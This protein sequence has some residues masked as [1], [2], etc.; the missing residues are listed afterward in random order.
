MASGLSPSSL[1]LK[2]L[3][4]SPKYTT[5]PSVKRRLDQPPDSAGSRTPD[6]SFETMALRWND[7]FADEET[8]MEAGGGGSVSVKEPQ[9]ISP[10]RAKL[11]KVESWLLK[12][13]WL[14][15]GLVTTVLIIY[16]FV[17]ISSRVT[18][19]NEPEGFLAKHGPITYKVIFDAGS[20]G[21]RVQ[22]FKFE[23]VGDKIKLDPVAP[24]SLTLF[25]KVDGGLSNYADDPTAAEDGLRWLVNEAIANVPEARG[26]QVVVSAT[27]GLRMLPSEKAEAL[28]ETTR[29]VMR[30]SP[31]TLRS[32]DD[33]YIMDGVDEAKF[34]WMTVDFAYRYAGL[35]SAVIDLG[36]GS[37]QLA[38]GIKNK[39][40]T[41]AVRAEYGS[42]LT[43]LDE[44]RS[45][46]VHSWL[47]YGLKAARRKVLEVNINGTNPCVVPESDLPPIYEYSGA[48]LKLIADD[49]ASAT[50]GARCLDTIKTAMNLAQQCGTDSDRCAF[51]GKW[52]GPVTANQYTFRLYSYIFDRA[53]QHGLVPEGDFQAVVTVGEFRS[54]ADRLCGTGVVDDP[55]ACMDM[56]YIVSLLSDG[57]GLKDD[58]AVVVAN[59]LQYGD[60]Q[61]EAAWP[62]GAA[63]DR[64][65]SDDNDG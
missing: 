17:I 60:F 21:S 24:D 49:Q 10:L 7:D 58:Q 54:L 56:S 57:F 27:A 19:K 25:R 40:L 20:T 46:Y 8:S 55:W 44:S 33:V 52:L 15:I 39:Q 2:D 3:S 59:K 14:I 64:L 47:G 32:D 38:Y 45:L 1:E 6:R 23:E 48:S 29:K 42:Y 26:A 43:P 4:L 34:Q 37:V 13:V 62:L 63:V 5:T 28:L 31:F 30:E 22:V 41:P 36:G 35:P 50:R 53:S 11:W 9:P 65:H 51:D 12:H 16:G 61:L 18:G